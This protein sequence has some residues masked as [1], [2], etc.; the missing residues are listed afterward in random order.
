[1]EHVASLTVATGIAVSLRDYR[2]VTVS[3]IDTKP[4]T[5]K[6]TSDSG[7][8]ARVT[9]TGVDTKGQMFR[10][11]A[12]ILQLEGRDCLFRSDRQPET[13]GSVLLEVDYRHAEPGHQVLHA[14][15]KSTTADADTGFY[16]AVVELET[17]QSRKILLTAIEGQTHASESAGPGSS[18]ATESVPAKRDPGTASRDIS[19][20]APSKVISHVVPASCEDA[21][22]EM[23]RQTPESIETSQTGNRVALDE[24]VK[25]AVAAELKQELERLRTSISIEL[26]EAL[27]G[28][29]SPNL[30]NV[31]REAVE[32][33][34][35]SAKESSPQGSDANAVQEVGDRITEL[36]VVFEG[37]VKK[38]VA[39]QLELSKTTADGLAQELSS[40]AAAIMRSMENSTS[41]IAQ[42][43]ADEQTALSRVTA[44]TAEQ[45]LTSRAAEI[46]GALQES[47][48]E[49]AKRLVDEQAEISRTA[50]DRVEQELS[51]R[52]AQIM[53]SFEE[54]TAD[55]ARKLLEQQTSISRAAADDAA[56]EQNLCAAILQSFEQSTAEL[57]TRINQ[58]RAAVEAAL[59]RSEALQN[60]INDR[61]VPLQ[62][63]LQQLNAI[64]GEGTETFKSQI[65]SEMN[66][67]GAQFEDQ[68][69]DMAR[70]RAIGFAEEIESRLAPNQRQADELLEKLGAVFQLLQTTA[71]V[72]QERLTEHS[73]ATATSFEKEIRAILLRFAGGSQH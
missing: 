24:A 16:T 2:S 40:H 53:R 5:A 57:E 7:G 71:R 11:P 20:R 56:R 50:G 46:M 33:Q 8:I 17:T 51:S 29:I 30:E 55:S 6:T 58:S 12:V 47:T 44:Q 36:R 13:G 22:I 60:E 64:S 14:S 49:M 41:E 34:A 54:F 62:R 25:S 32:K 3:T 39:E 73:K 66:R 31:V 61:M 69:N 72:Q 21:W 27:P 38:L 19:S 67:R 65:I 37:E 52:V 26:K 23:T 48:S 35:T 1:M 15:V 68:I 70:Q 43:L 45:Q 59:S 4:R 18:S 28:I 63:A 10:R 42:K 9:V